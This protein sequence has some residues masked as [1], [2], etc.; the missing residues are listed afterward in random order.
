MIESWT[1]SA[2]ARFDRLCSVL[3]ARG[4]G[5]TM[6]ELR[7][8]AELAKELDREEPDVE[9]VARLVEAL[10]LTE[11]EVEEVVG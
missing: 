6:L 1:T 2:L 10:G 9:A 8:A 7:D 3:G 4:R 5:L 11:D